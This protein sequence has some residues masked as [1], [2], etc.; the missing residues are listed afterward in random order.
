M[1]WHAKNALIRQGKDTAY[2]QLTVYFSDVDKIH[3]GIGD[4]IALLIQWIATFFGGFIVGFVREWRLTLLLL[5]FTPFLALGGAIMAKVSNI[6]SETPI[7][8]HITYI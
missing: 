4:K 6:S 8:L 7:L 3:D 1:T 5:A 2:S